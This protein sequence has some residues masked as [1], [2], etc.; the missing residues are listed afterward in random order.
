[1]NCACEPERSRMVNGSISSS[2]TI[3]VTRM[4]GSG[5]PRSRG[6]S[7]TISPARRATIRTVLWLELVMVDQQL[8]QKRGQTPTIADYEDGCPDKRILLI[9]RQRSSTPSPL[10]GPT[11][12]RPG[13]GSPE[14]RARDD[15]GSDWR[16]LLKTIRDSGRRT[17]C[18]RRRRGR[19]RHHGLWRAARSIHFYPQRGPTTTRPVHRCCQHDRRG[20]ADGGSAGSGGA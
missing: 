14:R 15:P 1:M 20:L 5:T 8:R 12:S 4:K 3:A 2:S 11:V 7:R 9:S 16:A 17:R 13:P 19:R 10:P 18:R 6:G